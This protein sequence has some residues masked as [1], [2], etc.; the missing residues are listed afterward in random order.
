[1]RYGFLDLSGNIGVV[2]LII[3]YLL[4]QLNRLSSNGLAYSLLN[5]MGAGLIALS[6]LGHFNLS[7]FLIEIFWVLISFIGIFRFLRIKVLRS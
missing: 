4:L 7:A 3:A 6:L 1:M 2:I 5:M